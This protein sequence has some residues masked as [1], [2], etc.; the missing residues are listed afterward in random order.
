[1]KVESTVAF[2]DN[3]YQRGRFDVRLPAAPLHDNLWWLDHREDTGIAHLLGFAWVCDVRSLELSPRG[4]GDPDRKRQ[5]DCCSEH[6]P[7]RRAHICQFACVRGF[8]FDPSI[9]L[10]DL[11]Q[12]A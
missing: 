10:P 11:I 8:A 12:L 2:G 5:N 3:I 1:V 9:F 7:G 6:R 4:G